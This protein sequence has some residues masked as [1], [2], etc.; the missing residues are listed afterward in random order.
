MNNNADPG[1]TPTSLGFG[2][3]RHI[4]KS[5]SAGSADEKIEHLTCA[6]EA[7]LMQ[8]SHL[9]SEARAVRTS[10]ETERV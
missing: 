2:A 1:P 8:I 9:E 3:E 6:V 4:E 7:L 10:A 5:K